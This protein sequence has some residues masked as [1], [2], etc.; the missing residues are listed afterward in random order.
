[1][2]RPS[3]C[4]PAAKSRASRVAPILF[5]LASVVPGTALPA[6]A[7]AQAKPILQPADYGRFETLASAAR[8]S[9]DGAWI[10]WVVTRVDE[11]SVLQ[12]RRTGDDTVRSFAFGRN[13]TFG[14]S[15]RWLAWEIEPSPQ[16]RARL[17]KDKKPVRSALGLLDLATGAARTIP[18]VASFAFDAAGRRLALLGYPPDEPKGRGGDLRVLD[19]SAGTEVVTAS[20]AEFVWHPTSAWL[21]LAIATGSDEGNGVQVHDA[22]TGRVLGLDASGSRYRALSWRRERADLAVLRSRERASRTDPAATLLVWR[23]IDAGIPGAR[24]LDAR[25]VQLPDSLEVVEHLRPEWSPDGTRLSLGLRPRPPARDSA[26]ATDSLPSLQL[27][28]TADVRLVPMQALRRTADAR[29]TLLAVWHVDS[30]RVV[31]AGSSLDEDASVLPG[32]RHAV[33]RVSAP[34]AWGTRFGRRYHD[35]YAVDLTSG[36]RRR[37]LEKVR[38]SWTSP[39]GRFVVSFDGTD[40][41]S[42]DLAR[43]RRVNLTGGLPAVF[44]DT[45]YDTPTDLP[46]PHPFG[47]FLAG[48]RGV[49]LQDQFDVWRVTLDGARRERLTQGAG[50]QLIHRVVAPARSDTGHDPDRALYVA[51]RGEWSEQRGYARLIPGRAPER[52]LLVDALVSGLVRADSVDVFAYRSERR[53]DSPDWYVTDDSWRAPRQVSR[54]NPFMGDYAW[55]HS[56]LFDFTSESN[57]R[58]QGVLLYPANHDPSRTYPMIVYT[59]EQLSQEAHLFEAPS[60]RDYYNFVTWTNRGYFVM[61]PDIVFRARDPGMSVLET[62]RPAVARVQAMGLIDPARVGLIGH[63]WGGYTAT[64]IP[65]RTNLFAA[66][67]A[68][69]PLTDFVS[70]MGQ[71]HWRAGMA[72]LEHWETGQARMEV[73]YWEDP[74]AHERNSPI[75]RVQDLE[76]PLLMAFGDN[77]GTVDWDQGTEFYNFARRAGKQM[78]LLVYE[79]E[80]HGFRRQANQVDYHRR[81]NEW[82]GHYLQGEPA[83]RWITDGVPVERI[84]DEK[85]RV[86]RPGVGSV[87]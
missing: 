73:P 39:G 22:A 84:D 87:P 2:S 63:S 33:E 52:L 47:G 5:V 16:D 23:G 65:T 76:T 15:S 72:E 55:T 46:P 9:P 71:I 11:G 1:M 45:T 37:V 77:D 80:D 6:R 17:A 49:L 83:P 62:L 18:A 61:L 69:A 53:D 35:V 67:V 19:L 13:A 58:L 7:A 78:V 24:M 41:W 81:I 44:R 60:E 85:R 25:A 4:R 75:H 70:F 34:Y 59:Y 30:N 64:F 86:A 26:S 14:S 20:V 48:D 42:D 82:F 43:G 68:G 28:H 12:V 56:A 57:R 38:Y 51:L 79:G 31:Q 29:R 40:Y 27:W 36:E 3:A 54:T 8:L 50:E 21:A 66:S 32:F 10:A 74:Q